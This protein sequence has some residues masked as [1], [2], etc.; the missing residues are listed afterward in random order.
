MET[1]SDTQQF[2]P[3]YMSWATFEGIIEQLGAVGVPDQ[4][5]RSVLNYRSGGDQSQ[6]LRAAKAF[7]LITD[8]GVPTDRLNE[9]VSNPEQRPEIYKAMLHEKYPKVIALG[10]GAT[11]Q[12][13]T[14]EFRE[15]GIE[16]DT[17]R[18]AI[19]FYINAAKHAD[20][21]LSPRFKSTRPGSGGRKA[22]TRRKNTGKQNQDREENNNPPPPPRPLA[23]LHPAVTTLV[24]SLP[25]SPYD[26]SKPEFSSA[27]RK[28]WF[29]YASATFNL[30]YARPSGDQEATDEIPQAETQ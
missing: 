20:I 23:G 17:V 28:A 13:L 9:L 15:F 27:E 30:I 5:D 25:T 24:Q 3:P 14:D 22:G 2:Q 18:K 1:E 11:Q 21:P 7:G 29:A 4:I 19:A 8:D 16:G 6:F 10:T 26:G 12:Q